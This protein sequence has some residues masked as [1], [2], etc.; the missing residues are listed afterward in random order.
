MVLS[1]VGSALR[2]ER[3]RRQFTLEHVSNVT[4]I[5]ARYLEAIENDRPQDLPGAVFVRGF[6]RQYARFLD[7][8]AEELLS[9]LPRV[10][11]ENAA[12]P[13]PPPKEF[14]PFWNPRWTLPAMGL[15]VATVILV[16]MGAAWF[17][18]DLTPT[19]VAAAK[20]AIS[21]ARNQQQARNQQSAAPAEPAAIPTP[22][23]QTG[24]EPGASAQVESGPG[25]AAV[26]PANMTPAAVE[27]AT[28]IPEPTAPGNSPAGSVQ[29]L[30]RANADAWVQVMADGKKAFSGMLHR[31]DSREISGQQLVRVMTG[32]A[33]GLEISLNGRVLDPIGPVGQVRT[34][35][36]TAD[37]L[38]PDLKTP[39]PATDPL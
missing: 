4:R 31:N 37:G 27:P 24:T 21:A 14:R 36:L 11:S 30:L 13:L 2:E 25:L 3:L 35:R 20:A 28:V 39:A 19:V 18:F 16:A 6:V 9:R 33:G 26:T 29:V 17:Y 38:L 15:S 1:G 32:N 8:P 5:S 34:V 12:L 7:L 10:D 22:T 23:L